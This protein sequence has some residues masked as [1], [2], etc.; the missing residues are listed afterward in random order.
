MIHCICYICQFSRPVNMLQAK[1]KRRVAFPFSGSIF[2]MQMICTD[3]NNYRKWCTMCS[4][5]GSMGWWVA[6]H[7]SLLSPLP[8]GCV[9]QNMHIWMGKY[10]SSCR[11]VY[12]G[13]EGCE[14]FSHWWIII[15]AYHMMLFPH[16]PSPRP[17]VKWRKPDSIFRL[18]KWLWSTNYGPLKCTITM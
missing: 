14:S 9:K 8:E 11:Q 13:T 5:F 12:Y 4:K 16:L 17:N 7:A 15:T 18:I 2:L 3:N 1:K 10:A 6:G